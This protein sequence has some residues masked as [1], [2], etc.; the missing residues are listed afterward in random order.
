MEA[1]RT[2]P[3]NPLV[4]QLLSPSPGV[5]C[6]RENSLLGFRSS[7]HF[8][9]RHDQGKLGGSFTKNKGDRV[10][11]K[12]KEEEGGKGGELPSLGPDP[13]DFQKREEDGVGFVL[14]L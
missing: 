3:N 10:G 6:H 2:V 12:Q 8:C 14:L 9:T 5:L 7:L 13:S 4:L 1:C 11:L